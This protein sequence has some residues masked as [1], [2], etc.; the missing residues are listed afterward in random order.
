MEWILQ[1]TYILKQ[2]CIQRPSNMENKQLSN[3]WGEDIGAGKQN[4][5][6]I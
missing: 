3:R 1:L 5:I 6:S 2:K 4:A